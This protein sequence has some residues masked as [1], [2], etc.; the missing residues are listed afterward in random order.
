MAEARLS[1]ICV[2]QRGRPCLIWGYPDSAHS[3]DRD[4]PSDR[5]AT[6]SDRSRPGPVVLTA[7]LDDSGDV[8]LLFVGQAR[9]EAVPVINRRDPRVAR[10]ALTAD[11][12]ARGRSLLIHPG[13]RTGAAGRRA[14][15]F[16]WL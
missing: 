11:V 1:R 6:C 12:A 10:S 9:P 15:E 14:Q 7:P 5:S 16:L 2:D 8:S 3:D 4:R 13:H